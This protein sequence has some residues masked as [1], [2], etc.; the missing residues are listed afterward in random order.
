VPVELVTLSLRLRPPRLPLQFARLGMLSTDGG[1]D[2]GNELGA[3]GIGEPGTESESPAL[4]PAYEPGLLSTARRGGER[5]RD[6]WCDPLVNNRDTLAV[7]WLSPRSGAG[8]GV[9]GMKRGRGTP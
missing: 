5:A 6:V 1:R 8:A 9:L 2:N 4:E 7:A 3:S